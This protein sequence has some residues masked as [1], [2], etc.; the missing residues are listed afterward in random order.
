[1]TQNTNNTTTTTEV[2]T[3]TKTK[4]NKMKERLINTINKIKE[5]LKS[6]T[7]KEKTMAAV[8]ATGAAL[9]MYIISN[10][11]TRVRNLVIVAN[12]AT[13]IICIVYALIKRNQK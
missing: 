1:M 3:T 11:P 6:S 5:A 2:T 7:T 4:E 8:A 10:L 9:W 13:A 12:I